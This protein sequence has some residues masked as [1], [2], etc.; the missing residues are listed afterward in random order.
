[1]ADRLRNLQNYHKKRSPAKGEREKTIAVLQNRQVVGR[2]VN[3]VRDGD[4]LILFVDG[5]ENE[6]IVRHDAPIGMFQGQ[7]IGF[8]DFAAEGKAFQ[9]IELLRDLIEQVQCGGRVA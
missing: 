5:V 8:D 9:T 2:A 1:M 4:R 7:E 3:D 6:V